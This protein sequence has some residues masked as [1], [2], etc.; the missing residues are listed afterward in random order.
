ME[1][2]GR[3]TFLFYNVYG[4][5]CP[6]RMTVENCGLRK[7]LQ[8]LN[9]VERMI[10]YKVL[11]NGIITVSKFVNLGAFFDKIAKSPVFDFEKEKGL[12][13]RDCK[14]Q[15]EKS[16][17]SGIQTIVYAHSFK[18]INCPEKMNCDTCPLRK[19]LKAME[20]EES[21]GYKELDSGELLIPNGIYNFK[22]N[23]YQ[24]F[25]YLQEQ[26]CDKCLKQQI[27]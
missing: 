21:I 7:R 12:T 13:C 23:T 22:N 17:K 20:G 4:Q 24:D 25:R 3:T 10:D 1:N 2:G 16:E 18:Y 5:Q 14:H 11:E 6:S 9:D 19:E 8:E 27:R 26:I 15:T